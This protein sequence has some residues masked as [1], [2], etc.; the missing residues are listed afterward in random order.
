MVNLTTYKLRLITEK[1]GIE[2]YKSISTEKVLNTF[3]EVD[4]NLQN[5][6]QNGHG[7]IAKM[8]NLSENELQQIIKMQNLLQNDLEQIAKMRHTK[9]YKNMSKEK[10]LIAL[11]KTEQSIAELRRSKVNNAE[12]EEVKKNLMH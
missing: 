3:D 4:H 1:R 5:I 6:S 10:L 2:N 12:T 8:Q 11:L 7:Q 9:N